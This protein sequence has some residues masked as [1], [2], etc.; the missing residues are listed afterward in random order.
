MAVAEPDN[1]KKRRKFKCELCTNV[2][3]FVRRP[4]LI[5]HIATV[6]KGQKEQSN[7]TAEFLDAFQRAQNFDLNT[8]KCSLCDKTF[9]KRG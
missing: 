5:R 6:H 9:P 7:F 1:G 3:A 2:Q 8:I 4:Q